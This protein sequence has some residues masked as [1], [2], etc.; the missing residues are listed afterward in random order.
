[1]DGLFKTPVLFIIFNRDDITCQVFNQLR[2]IRPKYLFVAADGPRPDRP[3]DAEKCL[4]TRN[5][6]RQIDWDCELKTLFRDSNLGCRLAVSSAVTWFFENVT[7]GI[8]LEDDCFPDLSFFG[9][10]EMLLEKYKEDESVFHINGT[11]F[12]GVK[13]KNPDSYYFTQFQSIWGWATWKRAWEHYDLYMSDYKAYKDKL[14]KHYAYISREAEKHYK[15]GF[16]RITE[17]HTSWDAQWMY[18]IIKF[19]GLTITPQ[20]NLIRNIGTTNNPTHSFLNDS[21]RDSIELGK[22]LLPVKHPEFIIN[23]R[24]DRLNFANYRG[25]SLYRIVRIIKEN[26]VNKVF[27]Y[28]LKVHF[29]L[30]IKIKYNFLMHEITRIVLCFKRRV[31]NTAM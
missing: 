20:V 9:Y 4:K 28:F 13:V 2:L 15:K 31:G 29:M 16:D 1:M 21:Y 17:E 18:V 19:N 22:M 25:K 26:G 10:C 27:L 8:I 30:Y 7:Q 11:D 6:I 5:I 12:S 23:N 14:F 24:I 3:E